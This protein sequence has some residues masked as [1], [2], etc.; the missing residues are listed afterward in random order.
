MKPVRF[1]AGLTACALTGMA[2]DQFFD[3]V[4]QA[5][6]FSAVDSRVRA[7]LSGTL[8]VEGYDYQLPAPG[9]IDAAGNQLFVPRLTVFLD[10]QFGPRFYAFL[11]ARADRGFD[12]A[13]ND[14][15]V[16][17]D[18]WAL[19][20]T[21]W[22]DGRINVQ[23]GKF[24]T[25]A[26]NWAARH[27]AWSNPFITAPLPYEHL[28]GIWDTE[29]IRNSN[30]LLQWS[31]VRPGLPASIT[32]VEKNLR[33]PI[34]WGPAYS[35]G[36]AV[37]GYLGRL[38]YAFDAK[39]GSLSSRPE[40]WLHGREQRHHPS[41]TGR[42][43]YRPNQMWN[44]GWSASTGSYLR[45]FAR[46]TVSTGFHRGDYR[47]T[48][49]AQDVSFAW[50]HL[51]VWAEVYASRFEIPRVGD[52]DTLAYYVEAKYKFTPRWFGALRWNEQLFGR[53]PDRGTKT[54]WGH[55]VWR[56]DVAPGFRFTP[57]TQLKFQYSLQHGDSGPRDFTRTLAT[58]FTLR[59]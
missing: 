17:L 2:D 19:R 37:S 24:A 57:H 44:V 40:A 59:F 18:E 51:Q 41:Y 25:V 5:L 39:L 48:V 1:L 56:V 29:A 20:Y 22:K 52:A 53:I 15:E 43:G 58:Q 46:P 13:P 35:T 49:L 3:R 11:Q 33:V 27:G 38:H 14:A 4:E 54:R 23:V 36:V 8:E 26:G 32:A 6:T 7:R 30:V 21:P 28:T 47:Q 42:I 34:V 45:E 16:R 12:P 31:H 50:H 9:V 55:N 10:A